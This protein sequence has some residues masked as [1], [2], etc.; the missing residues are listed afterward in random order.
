MLTGGRRASGKCFQ[1]RA[2]PN[3]NAAMGA[4]LG[5]VA[6]RKA[7]ARAVDRN[8]SK[9]LIRE[10]FRAMHHALGALDVVVLCRL[11][12]PR[13]ENAGAR[14]ELERLFGALAGSEARPHA[15]PQQE[16]KR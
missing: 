14:Y 13:G 2:R 10:M 9:R 7:V 8:R 3:A 4:R 6:G 12:V 16:F 1:V 15:T 11:P 5:I